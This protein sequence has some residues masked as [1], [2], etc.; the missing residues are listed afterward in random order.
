M[1]VRGV[2]NHLVDVDLVLH[3]LLLLAV[4]VGEV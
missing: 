2:G 4:V 3:L 1:R